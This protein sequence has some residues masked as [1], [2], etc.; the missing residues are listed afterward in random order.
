MDC[1]QVLDLDNL[2]MLRYSLHN[3]AC[4]VWVRGDDRKLNVDIN[5]R[6]QAG[7]GDKKLFIRPVR[8]K[9]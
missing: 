1:L 8:Q 5:G 4:I 6:W 7:V 2:S 9:R 3:I